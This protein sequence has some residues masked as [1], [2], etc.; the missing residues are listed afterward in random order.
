MQT[1]L[2]PEFAATAEGREAEGILRRCVH[3][4]FCT[5]TCPTYQLLG[6]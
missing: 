6:D 3:C 1:R 4:G 5:A 2:T